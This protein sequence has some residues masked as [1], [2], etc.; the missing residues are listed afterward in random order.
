[1]KRILIAIATLGL[2]TAVLAATEAHTNALIDRIK[3]SGNVCV[4]GQACDTAQVVASASGSG[5]ARDGA[6]VYQQACLACHMTGAAGAPI[7]GDAAA[8][9]ERIDKGLETLI[10]NS[11]SGIGAMPA[12]GGCANCSDEEIAAA[13]EYLVDNS[14]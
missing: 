8:W 1:M 14:R 11:I 2:A 6:T 7:M 3:P 13:T 4:A 5:A 9:A 12:K 10:A